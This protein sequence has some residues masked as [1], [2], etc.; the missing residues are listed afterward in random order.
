M[1]MGSAEVFVRM[2]RLRWQRNTCVIGGSDAILELGTD[3]PSTYELKGYDGSLLEAGV[4]PTLPPAVD[5]W[6]TLFASQLSNFSAAI[7]GEIALLCPAEEAA[8]SVRLID[9]CYS[10][11]MQLPM[12]WRD[13]VEI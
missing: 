8:Y 7:G 10:H 11:R 9:Q 6:E 5:G 2:S 4:V 12:S 1:H 13:R 3:T